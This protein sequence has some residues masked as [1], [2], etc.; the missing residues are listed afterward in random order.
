M[1]ENKLVRQYRAQ[2]FDQ[3]GTITITSASLSD[4]NKKIASVLGSGFRIDQ[5]KDSKTQLVYTKNHF[6]GKQP[7]GWLIEMEVPAVLSVK[8]VTENRLA[9]QQAA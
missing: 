1:N 5:Q 3:E 6:D 8:E 9:T 4:A 2:L 7:C